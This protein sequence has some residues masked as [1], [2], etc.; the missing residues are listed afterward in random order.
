LERLTGLCSFRL[1]AEC[2]RREV[3]PLKAD[4]TGKRKRFYRL[5]ARTPPGQIDEQ[6]E[7]RHHAGHKDQNARAEHEEAD[8][9]QRRVGAAE[10]PVAD[11]QP[12]ADGRD[13]DPA[14]IS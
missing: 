4:T 3:P 5:S 7:S 2:R 10:S 6:H 8:D 13:Q 1:Q 11:E 14:R 9:G 12:E